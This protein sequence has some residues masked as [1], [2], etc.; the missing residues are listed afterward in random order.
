MLLGAVLVDATHPALEDREVALNRVRV[1]AA[2]ILADV[3]ASRVRDRAMAGELLANLRV[4]LALV[5]ISALSRL[6]LVRTISV[7][8]PRWRA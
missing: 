1:D 4:E 6:T 3:L 2:V 5:V 8:S 7:T